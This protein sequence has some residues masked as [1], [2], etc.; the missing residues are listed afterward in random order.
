MDADI[1]SG[2]RTRN[3]AYYFGNRITPGGNFLLGFDYLRW[4]TD[5]K[6]FLPGISN[7][8]NIFMQYNF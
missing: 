4:L 1:P 2:G 5:Y 8:V 3:R 7:R 6:G